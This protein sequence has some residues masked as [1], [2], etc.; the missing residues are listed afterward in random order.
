MVENDVDRLVSRH[1]GV[2]SFA[3]TDEFLMPVHIT[4]DHRSIQHVERSEYEPGH[5]GFISEHFV[6]WRA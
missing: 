4:P 1:L 3:E 6:P 2:K 5:Q